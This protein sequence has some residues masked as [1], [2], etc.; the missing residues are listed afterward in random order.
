LRLGSLVRHQPS[1]HDPR[2]YRVVLS[3]DTRPGQSRRPA[4]ARARLIE[5]F[6]GI[7][8]SAELGLDKPAPGFYRAMIQAAGCPVE[9]ILHVGNRMDNDVVM[10]AV[11]GM[12]AALAAPASHRGRLLPAGAVQ[13]SHL[14]D[15]LPHLGIRVPPWLRTE[16][17]LSPVRAGEAA[18]ITGATTRSLARWADRG[19]LTFLHTGERTVRNYRRDEIDQF[20]RLTPG[21]RPVTTAQLT[22]LIH[23]GSAPLSRP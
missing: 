6:T 8:E 23:D 4:L 21:V 14:I 18:M 1:V 16:N 13:I 10:P 7:V 20:T 17:P 19:W 3:S 12:R 5:R 2:G 22:R 9:Q 11:M 15:L